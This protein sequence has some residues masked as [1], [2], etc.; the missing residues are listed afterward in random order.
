MACRKKGKH[1]ARHHRH[2][3]QPESKA[4]VKKLAPLEATSAVN[5]TQQVPAPA[6]AQ[7]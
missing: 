1:K 5:T 7:A 4:P 3:V 6:V 2:A